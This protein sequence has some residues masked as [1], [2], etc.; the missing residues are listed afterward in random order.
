MGFD[1][2]THSEKKFENIEKPETVATEDK[3]N[4]EDTPDE[5]PDDPKASSLTSLDPNRFK[6][7]RD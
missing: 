5:V 6:I 2:S 3:S 1:Q 4:A 7:I